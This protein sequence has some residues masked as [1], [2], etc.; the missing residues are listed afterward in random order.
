[1]ITDVRPRSRGALLTY[2]KALNKDYDKDLIK[3]KPI[4]KK[5]PME[6]FQEFFMYLTHIGRLKEWVDYVPKDQVFREEFDIKATKYGLGT[7]I[8]RD[9]IED[10][11]VEVDFER[12]MAEQMGKQ[13]ALAPW[14]A[15]SEL[16]AAGQ[17]ELC[18]IDNTAYFSVRDYCN[19]V[20][21]GSGI[22]LANIKTDLGKVYAR[23]RVFKD[24]SNTNRQGRDP[25]YIFADP[26]LIPTFWEVARSTAGQ[27]EGLNEGAFNVWSGYQVF[28]LDDLSGTND[29]IAC[30][31]PEID[32]YTMYW[33]N[34]VN[35]V[36]YRE[37][38]IDSDTILFVNRTRF[39]VTFGW[40]TMAVIVT[41]A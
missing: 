23:M 30:V 40:P 16:L 24:P 21:S 19:N 34:R 31:N 37:E 25:K 39:V 12:Y 6:N 27:G 7:P 14:Y 8:K 10:M 33:C 20:I 17:T 35:P 28:P 9:A 13:A 15:A 29:W 22:T 2:N 3:L 11:R 26:I 38:D 41:N 36:M 32:D 4:T 18:P 1:M 5:I